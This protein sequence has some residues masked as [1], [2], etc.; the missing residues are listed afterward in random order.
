MVIKVIRASGA[1]MLEDKL[2]EARKDG[3]QLH[4][5]VAITSYIDDTYGRKEVSFMFIQLMVKEK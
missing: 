5:N 3:W 4:G 1:G 2:N